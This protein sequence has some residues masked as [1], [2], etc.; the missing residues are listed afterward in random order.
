[1]SKH[2]FYEGSSHEI[3]LQKIKSVK[4]Q[5]WKY[6]NVSYFVVTVFPLP[7]PMEIEVKYYEVVEYS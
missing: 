6:C 3:N 7:P 5:H 1:M 4:L 2:A